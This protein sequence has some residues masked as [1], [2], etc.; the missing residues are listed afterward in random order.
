VHLL[1]VEDHPDSRR[2]L[3]IL[4]I[5]LGYKVSSAAGGAEALLYVNSEEHFDAVITDVVMPGMSGVEFARLARAARPGLPIVLLTGN[6][7]GITSAIA[8]GAVA[9]LKPVTSERLSHVLDDALGK[10][11]GD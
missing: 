2:T 9:L 11:V 8:S 3:A 6:A 5:N 4:L 7:D 10:R 1:L